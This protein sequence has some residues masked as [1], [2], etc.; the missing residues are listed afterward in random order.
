MSAVSPHPARRIALILVGCVS[1]TLGIVGAFLPVLPTTCFVLLAAACFARSSPRLERWLVEHRVF[2][3]TIVAWRR[4][5]AMPS[6]AKV[7]AFTMLGVS[8]P[9]SI[10]AVSSHAWLPLVLAAMGLAIVGWIATIP[11]LATVKTS[12]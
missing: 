4:H 8:F 10:W 3:P 5:R 2:G 6:H 11:T 7:A 1:L 9:L 12:S